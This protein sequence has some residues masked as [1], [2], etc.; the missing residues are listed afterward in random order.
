MNTEIYRNK[1]P[2]EIV[3]LLIISILVAVDAYGGIWDIGIVD[4]IGD[5]GK[6]CE[7][8]FDAAGNM[9]AVYLRQDTGELM[10]VSSIGT[11]WQAPERVD[12]TG[13]VAGHCAIAV[14]GTGERKLS[15]YRSD[16]GALWY[17]GPEE[18]LVW[19]IG[20]VTSSGDDIGRYCA[21]SRRSSGEVSLSCRN[22]TQE[23]LL[24]ILRDDLGVWAAPQTVD[25]GP[26]RGMHCDHAY[27]SGSGYVFS[28]YDSEHGS[29]IYADPVLEPLQWEIGTV[30]EKFESGR[31]VSSGLAPDGRVASAFYHYG[32]ATL[33][34]ILISVTDEYGYSVI[35]AVEDSIASGPA[36]DVFIDLAITPDW[37]WHISYRSTID[38][39]L[40]YASIESFVVT[41]IEGDDDEATIP[42]IQN[43]RLYQNVPNPFN[44]TT[45]IRFDLPQA[46]DV[47]LSVYTVSGEHV[48]TLVD[49]HLDAGRKE[50]RWSA[51]NDRGK[52]VAS[53]IYF[54]Q[55]KAGDLVQTKKMVLLR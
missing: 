54:Y 19:E 43:L 55:I 27:Y 53:G 51:R 37:D 34:S 2:I 22:E 39:F 41:G 6:Y 32:S 38:G 18:S 13:S 25:P 52:V 33:G 21:A 9:H 4:N 12:T 20:P 15:Y 31:F 26:D 35:K 23:S 8:V 45:T 48:A 30:Y 29:L 28:E 50:V 24:L 3:G 36:D 16:T 7:L 47:K 5:V 1:S 44:P 46:A 10:V 42:D 40:W 14:T 11:S 17:A 49:K